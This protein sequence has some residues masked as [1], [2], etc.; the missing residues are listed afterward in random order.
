MEVADG[1]GNHSGG[2]RE[3][4]ARPIEVG[5]VGAGLCFIKWKTTTSVK[6]HSIAKLNG[7]LRF[8]IMYNFTEFW[9]SRCEGKTGGT[10]ASDDFALKSS[11]IQTIF[12]WPRDFMIPSVLLLFAYSAHLRT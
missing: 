7:I 2:W 1:G 12:R 8:K 5:G 6:R 11:A 9:I 3:G 4:C 10:I